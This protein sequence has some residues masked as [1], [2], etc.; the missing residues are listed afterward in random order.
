MLILASKSAAR[1]RLLQNAGLLIECQPAAIDERQTEALLASHLETAEDSAR[2]LARAKALDVSRR[3]LTSPIVGADQTLLFEGRSLHKPSNFEE[4]IL[5]LKSLRGATHKLVSGVALA[6]DG[7]VLWDHTEIAKLTMREISDSELDRIVSLEGEAIVDCV[8]AYRFE[9]P[10][11]QL[12]DTIEGDYFTILGLPLLPLLAALR[13]HA[14]QS[15]DITQ[16]PLRK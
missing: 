10:S 4:A 11:I 12:F 8:G 14:P 9:G 2:L 3:N 16:R 15:F 13:K 1:R 7:E 6:R 5:H